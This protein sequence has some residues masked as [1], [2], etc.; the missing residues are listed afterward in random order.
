MT[1]AEKIDA[2]LL[3]YLPNVILVIG[4]SV[5]PSRLMMMQTEG[6]LAFGGAFVT[7]LFAITS[8]LYARAR[9]A[10]DPD[11]TAI[12]AKI[13]DECLKLSLLAILGYVITAYA[14]LALSETYHAKLGHILNPAGD[15]PEF[16]PMITTTICAVFFFVP[17]AVKIKLVIEMTL[18]NLGLRRRR[19][20]GRQKP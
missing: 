10:P 16:W 2:F 9:A 14:F 1:R 19:D 18:Q 6:L 3:H 20:D 15:K 12:R 4:L 8:L 17:V 5:L 7:A 11:E 13:A